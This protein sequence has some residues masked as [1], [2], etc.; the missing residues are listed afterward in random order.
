M[1]LERKSFGN[2]VSHLVTAT[3]IWSRTRQLGGIFKKIFLKKFGTGKLARICAKLCQMLCLVVFKM[4]SKTNAGTVN[5]KFIIQSLILIQIK[6]AY[7]TASFLKVPV[8]FI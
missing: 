1:I 6:V 7:D 5:I 2:L 4:L 3:V 8:K